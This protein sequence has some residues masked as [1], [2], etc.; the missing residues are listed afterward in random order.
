MTYAATLAMSS[1]ESL[2]P[3]AGMAFFPLVTW[4]MMDFSERPPARYWSRASFSKVFSGMITFCP[5]AWQA[6]QLALKTCSP[7]PA[8]AAKTGEVATT[9]AAAP[10]AKPLATCKTWQRD[11]SV[12]VHLPCQQDIG[13]NKS[14]PQIVSGNYVAIEGNQ[15]NST[16]RLRRM[17]GCVSTT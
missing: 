11:R 4:V 10:A 16:T 12:R 9:A 3:N 8:S 15:R 13:I 5:P 14:A 2:P 1:S 7:A 17:Y 6:A